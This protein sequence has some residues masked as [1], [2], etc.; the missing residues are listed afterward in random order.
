MSQY[1]PI[2]D[3]YAPYAS[4]QSTLQVREFEPLQYGDPV[5]RLDRRKT[6][7]LGRWGKLR[8]TQFV[9]DLFLALIPIFFIGKIG[10]K[11]GEK[12]Y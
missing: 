8:S 2:K 6:K 11:I 5:H 12:M 4:S 1:E 9:G 7:A 10:Q 3:P